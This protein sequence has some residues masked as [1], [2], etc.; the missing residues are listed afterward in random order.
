MYVFFPNI[1]TQCTHIIGVVAI[2]SSALLFVLL[3]F[4]LAMA[5]ELIKKIKVDSGSK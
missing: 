2:V 5:I 1:V 4:P 3:F